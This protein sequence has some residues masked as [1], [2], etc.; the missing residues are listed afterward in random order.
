MK[1]FKKFLLLAVIAAVLL[2]ALSIIAAAED[3]IPSSGSFGPEGDKTAPWGNYFEW[4]YDAQSKTMHIINPGN[5]AT[6][7]WDAN[8]NTTGMSMTEWKAKYAPIT[9]HIEVDSF[10]RHQQAALYADWTAAKSIHFATMTRLKVSSSVGLFSGCTS[11]TKVW[12]GNGS[13][14]DN[15]I[16]LR[17]WT[18]DKDYSPANSFKNLL[19]GCTSAVKV[20]LPTSNSADSTG[21]AFTTI[22]ATTFAGCTSLESIVVGATVTTIDDGAFEGCPNALI[23]ATANETVTAYMEANPGIGKP[24]TGSYTGSGN[25]VSME[26]KLLNGR[27][28]LTVTSSATQIYFNSTVWINFIKS[29]ASYV[30]EFYIE[31]ADGI[32][33]P[34]KMMNNESA[35]WSD[36]NA[37]N[38]MDN[39][40]KVVLPG[41]IKEYAGRLW[42]NAK[43]LTTYGPEGTPEGTIDLSGV[44]KWSYDMTAPF[45]N[46]PATTVI[47]PNR[48]TP[49]KL[50]GTIT[51]PFTGSSITNVIVPENV[52]TLPAD[53]FSGCTI[54]NVTFEGTAE[55]VASSL[56]AQPFTDSADLTFT[57]NSEEAA[58]AIRE[59][60]YTLATIKLNVVKSGMHFDGWEIRNKSY[61]NSDGDIITNGLRGVMYF[62]KATANDGFELVEYGG[63]VTATANKVTDLISEDGTPASEKIKKFAIYK[64][65]EISGKTLVSRST[66][67]RTYFAITVVN[68]SSHYTSDISI[69]GYEI[70]KN[71]STD[72]IKIIY[73]DYAT[74][75]RHD[76]SYA[77]TNIYEISLGMY[78]EGVINSSNDKES[79]VW[80]VL[81]NGGA[82]KLAAG[83]D[84][85]YDSAIDQSS[86]SESMTLVN[87]PLAE[88]VVTDGNITFTESEIK[89]SVFEDGEN[90]A[91]ILR[92]EGEMP[93]IPE[94][95][96]PQY[97][98]TWYTE[99]GT[100]SG[101]RPQPIFSADFVSGITSVFVD[102]G[103]TRVGDRAFVGSSVSS[104]ICSGTVTDISSSALQGVSG[105]E[106][107]LPNGLTFFGTDY[108]NIMMDNDETVKDSYVIKREETGD[109]GLIYYLPSALTAD[110]TAVVSFKAYTEDVY[111]TVKVSVLDSSGTV[112]QTNSYSLSSAWSEISMP[113][114]A[115]G[116]ETTVKFELGSALATVHIGDIS[117][118]E[119]DA[120]L[121]D[122]PRGSYMLASEKWDTISIPFSGISETTSKVEG[123][124]QCRDIIVSDDGEY[125]YV[126]GDG[127]L[128]IY[129]ANGL[130]PTLI[131]TI[132][133]IGDLRQ[134]VMT[135][136][137]N[138][139]IITARAS[140]VF[141]YDITDRSNPKFASRIDSAEHAT[142]IDTSG[143]YCYIAD[144]VFGAGIV[145]ISDLYNP[146]VTAYYNLGECQDVAFYNGYIYCGCWGWCAVEVLDVRDPDNPK[147]VTELTLSGRGDGVT[148]RNG[149]L[150]AAT[151]HYFRDYQSLDSA[152]YGLGNGMDIF[153]LTDPAKPKKISVARSDGACYYHSPDLWRVTLSGKYAFL[154]DCFCGLYVYDMTNPKLPVR[155]AHINIQ[156]KNGET[157]Y[158]NIDT[159]DAV[160]MPFD[161][162]A[163][164]NFPIVDCD[165]ADGY[166]YIVGYSNGLYI[167]KT[168]LALGKSENDDST[169][170]TD[171][172]YDLSGWADAADLETLGFTNPEVFKTDTQIW[173]VVE[174]DGKLYVAAGTDG[175]YV[176]DTDMTVLNQIPSQ[177]ITMAIDIG[178]DG[179]VYTA[180]STAGLCV[181]EFDGND[182]TKLTLMTKFK[183]ANATAYCDLTVSP[184]SKYV[185]VQNGS[186]SSLIDIR[187]L[188]NIVRVAS[189]TE[190][191]MVYQHLISDKSVNNR[192][193][194]V[195]A[196]TGNPSALLD[197][198]ENGSYDAPVVTYWNSGVNQNSGICSDGERIFAVVGDYIYSFDPSVEGATNYTISAASNPARIKYGVKTGVGVPTVCGDY[199]FVAHRYSGKYSIYKFADGDHT[200]APTL[201]GTYSFE[202][203]GHPSATLVV[204]DRAYLPMGYSGLAAFDL[205]TE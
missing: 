91:L 108:G 125:I 114:T 65:G 101:S 150:Y 141:I 105:A 2:T 172:E 112:L 160:M 44:V 35:Q 132:E 94:G 69:C 175:I 113:L 139:L 79:I 111:T 163:V 157:G 129:E 189:Y 93:N 199:L 3:T 39:C 171:E 161:T 41:H 74:D 168:D 22:D 158:S 42:Q 100:L 149:I 16:D 59:A 17:G 169:V 97:H 143:D 56:T 182:K 174:H 61:K 148:I 104:L 63:L 145:N 184:A 130:N 187:D 177:D 98:S 201:V 117:V 164:R 89:Y 10:V 153:D 80:D 72:E 27:L 45:K 34:Y 203:K 166:L 179:R 193:L 26:W 21:V 66:E 67:Q 118:D 115:T 78:K 123:I 178:D 95:G 77:D 60:G 202:N 32:S 20:I 185:L 137:G 37:F 83:T 120:S 38:D 24:V 36:W 197:F 106:I 68:F 191:T 188:D 47:L 146:V 183:A 76:A 58:A 134:M 124:S 13:G 135:D 1:K 147:Y 110:K 195:V 162:T 128:Y 86:Y 136:D 144:R 33:V 43:A 25:N 103:V 46:I 8:C 14:T 138:G 88:T 12:I 18:A 7:Y 109:L 49:A 200:A 48:A 28:T 170:F 127:N 159:T 198:G 82:V 62:E 154:S 156:A 140:G 75:P 204:G 119:T 5:T 51:T 152:R 116:T 121:Y 142:G 6:F 71:T 64:D 55:N 126:I 23:D 84:Y 73:T 11:L 52:T 92:G 85:T 102:Y 181:Y 107:R 53:F 30:K 167:Y 133:D 15:V 122:A 192:Y 165:M 96:Y 87:I 40:T 180:E 176:L 196:T 19:S 173:E 131:N 90:Y 99:L 194:M 31:L 190:Y 9:E 70:W 155:I 205:P 57:V 29:Y 186:M 81:V 50:T 54:T 4:E 151:G